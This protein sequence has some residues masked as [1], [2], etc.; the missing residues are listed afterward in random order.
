MLTKV[1]KEPDPDFFFPPKSNKNEK[2]QGLNGP[3]ALLSDEKQ[4]VPEVS[5]IEA[6]AETLRCLQA[7]MNNE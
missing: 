7:L 6:Q 2:F 1:L 4:K 3:E 5:W